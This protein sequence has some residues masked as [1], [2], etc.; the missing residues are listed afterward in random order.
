MCLAEGVN[1]NS[2]SLFVFFLFLLDFVFFF[3]LPFRFLS[4]VFSFYFFLSTVPSYSFLPS[5]Y[6]FTVFL[7]SFLSVFLSSFFLLSISL[8]FLFHFAFLSFFLSFFHTIQY[9]EF[10][11]RQVSVNYWHGANKVCVFRFYGI[12]TFIG[13]LM[14]N[15][16]LYK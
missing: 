15:L 7:P 4:F 14:P 13:Y 11:S 12:S 6:I 9:G 8:P 16:F 5:F 1:Q 3:F 10:K 2:W